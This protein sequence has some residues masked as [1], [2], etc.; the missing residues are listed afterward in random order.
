MPTFVSG[1][2]LICHEVGTGSVAH[3]PSLLL[4]CLDCFFLFVFGSG[5]GE[6]EVCAQFGLRE[7]TIG[8]RGK[9]GACALLIQRY[10][11]KKENEVA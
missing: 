8:E 1:Y 3:D 10:R 2:H 7:E 4:L 6:R 11:R 5:E 9:A